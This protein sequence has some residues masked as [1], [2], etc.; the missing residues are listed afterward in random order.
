MKE[1]YIELT[2]IDN[3]YTCAFQTTLAHFH[4]VF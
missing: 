1:K 4:N 3:Y 2:K